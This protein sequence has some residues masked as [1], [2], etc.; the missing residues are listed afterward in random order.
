MVDISNWVYPVSWIST[1]DYRRGKPGGS[2][3]ENGGPTPTARSRLRI[4]LR[5]IRSHPCQ[6][7]RRPDQVLS[8]SQLTVPNYVGESDRP[9]PGKW[10]CGIFGFRRTDG[11][12]TGSHSWKTRRTRR[13]PTTGRGGPQPNL[14][15]VVTGTGDEYRSPESPSGLDTLSPLHYLHRVAVQLD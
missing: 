7:V 12:P 2:A 3:G 4:H 8:I 1:E 5:R 6:N 10:S 14:R 13:P 15:A 11:R 9:G